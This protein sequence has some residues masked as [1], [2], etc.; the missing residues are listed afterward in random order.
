[1]KGYNIYLRKDGR[2]EGRIPKPSVNGKR[3]YKSFF[4]PSKEAVRRMI[5][6]FYRE[7]T[8]DISLRFTQI[9][10]E[11][12]NGVK[13]HIKESTA[14]NYMMK[15]DKHLIPVFGE[16]EISDITE[17]DIHSFI[18]SRK[19]SGLS[20][21]YISD[22]ISLMRSVCKYATRKYQVNN[23]LSDIRLFKRRQA[24]IQIL[25]RK[26]HQKLAEYVM[27]NHNRTNLGIAIAMAAGPRIGE[28]CAFRGR[29]IDFE[30]RTLTVK[31]TIQRIQIKDGES[32]TK[33]IIS[34][35][36]SDSSKRVI[37]IPEELIPYLE[38]FKVKDDE[39]VLSGTS[40]PIEPR[41]LQNRFARILNNVNL[42][43]VHFHSLRHY[44]ASDCVR[45]G[46]DIKT[47]SEL[48]GHSNVEITL[49]RYVHSSFDQKREY[50]NR[51]K[52][53]VENTSFAKDS[54]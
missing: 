49:N 12:F 6:D 24:E 23:P 52:F 44:F 35:P 21:R 14:A 25:D 20:D 30:K 15:A 47:L 50:M 48:L 29:D 31:N 36:K 39:F 42:P 34:E 37:P 33:I 22:I 11:W 13:Y 43:S 17:T 1:M 19:R 3:K 53:S 10:Q 41:T 7:Q 40:K 9:Y 4:G 45:L 26:E 32:K 28:I 8:K 46:F 38:E 2:W 27:K 51:I 5:D 54:V 18:D 16:F